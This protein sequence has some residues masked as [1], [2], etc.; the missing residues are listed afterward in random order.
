MKVTKRIINAY[1]QLRHAARNVERDE[2]ACLR[3]MSSLHKAIRLL[4]HCLSNRMEFGDCY[5]P[6]LIDCLD[7]LKAVLDKE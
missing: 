1:R 2:E 7:K 5:N 6:Q 3:G 4:L